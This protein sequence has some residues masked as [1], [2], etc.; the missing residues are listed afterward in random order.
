MLPGFI[1]CL[2]GGMKLFELITATIAAG[3]ADS[4]NPMAITQQFVLQG[5]VKKP[6]HIW[7]FILPTGII[8]LL[9]GYL[10]YFGVI[11]NVGGLLSGLPDSAK[12]ALFMLLAAAGVVLLG[13][14]AATAAR[15]ILK[16]KPAKVNDAEK[17]NADEQAVR[18]KIKSVTPGAL[19]LLGTGATFA[20]LMTSMPYFAFLA[21]MFGFDLSFWQISVLL[22]VYNILY[23]LPLI[24]MYIVY[25]TAQKY[26]DRFY[27]FCKKLLEKASGILV[28]VLEAGIGGFCLVWGAMH[29]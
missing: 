7:Y 2:R 3:A 17:E 21:Y 9:F 23:M 5:L 8:S 6:H 11:E 4:L 12:R 28:P 15:K 1:C 13:V 25:V 27:M 18:K 16:N 14:A 29:I 26:F 20:E 24:V 19:V 10:A 22:V